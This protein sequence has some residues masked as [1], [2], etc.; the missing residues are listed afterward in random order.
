MWPHNCYHAK[1]PAAIIKDC[2]AFLDNPQ[3]P[4]HR[5]A[6]FS[7]R[8]ELIS[9]KC[10]KTTYISDEQRQAIELSNYHGITAQVQGVA[11]DWIS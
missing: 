5:V 2:K 1:H 10:R 9:H 3:D 7:G 6:I 4:M 11:G 8:W